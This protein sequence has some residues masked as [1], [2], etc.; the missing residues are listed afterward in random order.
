[1]QRNILSIVVVTVLFVAIM[2]TS[3]CASM[4]SKGSYGGAVGSI[5][6]QG[7]QQAL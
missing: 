3:G 5:D 6:R 2:V 7:S 4:S 1:M